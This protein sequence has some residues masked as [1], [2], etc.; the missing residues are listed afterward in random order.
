MNKNINAVLLASIIFLALISCGE[1]S[2]YSGPN[3]TPR[4]G[5]TAGISKKTNEFPFFPGYSGYYYTYYDNSIGIDKND[6]SVSSPAFYVARETSGTQINVS[7]IGAKKT[8]D[9]TSNLD[10]DAS[11]FSYNSTGILTLSESGLSKI[12]DV[13]LSDGKIYKYEITFTITR[14]NSS[15]NKPYNIELIEGE[16]I[17]DSYIDSL[18]E[19]LGEVKVKND[20][21]NGEAV[22][23]FSSVGSI[24]GS[25][26]NYT[27]QASSSATG[28]YT[29]LRALAAV[30]NKFK[31]E[32][33]D[34][35]YFSK[36]YTKGHYVKESDNSLILYI[37]CKTKSGYIIPKSVSPAGISVRL[38]L[39]SQGKWV[40]K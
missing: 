36:E 17:P 18:M 9:N 25:S 15:T 11:H 23:N 40:Y 39:G 20:K 29:V 1:I 19:S 5:D 12:K 34:S 28:D 33:S 30:G 32:I 35:E 3:I 4:G 31:L 37:S 21:F 14:N 38:T 22:F 27:V 6:K 2:T 13:D 26:P 16:P 10:L 8:S 7:M 24:S